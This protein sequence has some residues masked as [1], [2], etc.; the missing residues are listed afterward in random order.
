MKYVVAATNPPKT[1]C[2]RNCTGEVGGSVTMK[3]AKKSAAF[4]NGGRKISPNEAAVVPLAVSDA[5]VKSAKYVP[6]KTSAAGSL[7]ARS[8]TK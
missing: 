8:A 2:S 7:F 4:T 3:K 6:R 1:I 5:P